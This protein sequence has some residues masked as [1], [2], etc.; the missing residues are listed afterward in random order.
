MGVGF[1]RPHTPLHA[2]DKYFNYFDLNDVIVDESYGIV[3]DDSLDTTFKSN[4]GLTMYAKM[5]EAYG[6]EDGLKRV[7]Q[8]YLACIYAV[9]DQ[10]GRVLTSLD[11]NGFSSNTII[12][13]LSDHGWHNGQKQVMWKNTAWEQAAQIPLII[14]DPAYQPGQVQ[15]PVSMIDIFP[16]LM[17]LA[18]L[19]ITSTLTEADGHVLDG[20]SLK[21][22]LENPAYDGFPR[23]G[24]ITII[25]QDEWA[26]TKSASS[27]QWDPKVFT[28][29]VRMKDYRYIMVKD[30]TEELYNNSADPYELTNLL[31]TSEMKTSETQQVKEAAIAVLNSELSELGATLDAASDPKKCS[32][33][34]WVK[35]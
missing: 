7:T 20:Y 16:T 13:F 29:S 25:P 27:N 9:D 2:P 33:N 22:F 3:A 5:V 35:C 15:F 31:F 11:A 24:A 26:Y 14:K 8:A 23:A 1:V 34:L 30:G 18:G 10:I 19:E 32:E 12:V 17:D 6:L 4:K 21:P 28:Y